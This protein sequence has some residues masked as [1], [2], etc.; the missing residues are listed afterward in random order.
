MAQ[1]V[2]P[3]TQPYEPYV[4]L[5]RAAKDSLR[6]T[7]AREAIYYSTVGVATEWNIAEGLRVLNAYG[8]FDEVSVGRSWFNTGRLRYNLG[9]L[10]AVVVFVE[11][12]MVGQTSWTSERLTEIA[13]F[14]GRRSMREWAAGGFSLNLDGPATA[15]PDPPAAD[16][17]SSAAS[18]APEPTFM[19]SETPGSP[20]IW[21]L[22]S[23]VLASAGGTQTDPLYRV[24][25]VAISEHHVIVAEASTGSLRF[26][27]HAGR[28]D[29]TVGR[30]GEGPGE[31]RNMGWM[32]R[33]RD[34]I[35]VYDRANN[36]VVGYSFDGTRVRS[37]SVRPDVELPLTSVVGSFADG[38]LLAIAVANPMYVPDEAETRR[39]PMTLVRHDSEGASATRLIDMVGPERYF[40]PSGRGGV[41]QMSRPFGRAT[42]VAVVDS[43]FVVMDNDSYAISVYGRD[44]AQSETL[45][46][47]PVPPM[48][49]LK[50]SDIEWAREGL[51]A[52]ADERVE[53]FVE[54][55]FRAGFPDHLPPYGWSTFERG[56]SRPPLIVADGFVFALRY[57]G[58]ESGGGEIANPEWFVFRPGEGH[59][60]TLTSPDDVR[61]LDLTGDVAAVVRKTEL[62]EEV[63]ELRRVL[64]R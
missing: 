34:E 12:I 63:V 46:P 53:R 33:V 22:D 2:A 16:E 35:H 56:D 31:Y 15:E 50:Q 30:Q 29:K 26:Y 17:G 8:S 4:T 32:H 38:S 24:A 57:G 39:L 54:G 36:R 7:A 9:V 60:A 59:V 45:M 52:G 55:M 42:G 51:L 49:P 19:Q 20:A 10:P 40:E 6:A 28:L 11:D 3:G 27:T 18:I 21:R 64:G 43:I 23:N 41:Q 37:V 61:L 47:E 58:I 5:V 13:R 62:G 44:G 48:T 14:E 1:H 25:G